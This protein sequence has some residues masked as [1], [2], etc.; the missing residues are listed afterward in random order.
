MFTQFNY[1]AWLDKDHLSY[2][3]KG[4]GCLTSAD[5]KSMSESESN[6]HWESTQKRSSSNS[7]F[8][9]EDACSPKRDRHYHD[10]DEHLQLV[11]D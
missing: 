1:L 6:K 11:N 3:S 10:K 2:K 5:M 7:D 4:D 8:S 9:D